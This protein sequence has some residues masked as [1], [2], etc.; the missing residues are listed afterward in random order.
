MCWFKRVSEAEATLNRCEEKADS[1]RYHGLPKDLTV[2]FEVS[3]FFFFHHQVMAAHA[4]RT[5]IPVLE[6]ICIEQLG[7]IL[8]EGG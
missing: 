2:S 6:V 7:L 3:F 4:F 1:P 8:L 5:S